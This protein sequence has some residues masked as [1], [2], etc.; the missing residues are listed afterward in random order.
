MARR[1]ALA[2]PISAGQTDLVGD[3]M[4]TGAI[5]LSV[6][7][8]FFV[9]D[10]ALKVWAQEALA[11]PVVLASWLVL[12]LHYNPEIVFGWLPLDWMGVLFP[13]MLL[14]AFCWLG[15]RMMCSSQLSVAVGFALTASGFAG[16]LVDR[17][18]G[19]V[20][21]YVALG[22]VAGQ[23]WAVFNLADVALSTGGVILGVVVVK[24][25]LR[26]QRTSAVVTEG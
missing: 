12:V 10:V 9:A 6:F 19:A 21:D 5:A 20:I 16:N 14:P 17:L 11:Q 23:R 13:F 4:R 24:R 15:W 22:P 8:G 3:E 18:N 25:A 7:A 2:H 1:R 26:A